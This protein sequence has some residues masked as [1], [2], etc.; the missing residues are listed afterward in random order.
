VDPAIQRMRHEAY[1]QR[2][3]EMMGLV[4]NERKKIVN[5]E[6]AAGHGDGGETGLTPGAI[7]AAQSKA[8]ATFVELEEKRMLKMKKRQVSNVVLI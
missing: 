2:R 3:H 8:N 6:V 5:A 4:R 1:S 7:L